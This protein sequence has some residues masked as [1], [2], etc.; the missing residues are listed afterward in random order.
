MCSFINH[1]SKSFMRFI[2]CFFDKIFLSMR[3]N[4]WYNYTDSLHPTNRF[5]LGA[6]MWSIGSLTFI[7]IAWTLTFAVVGEQYSKHLELLN[8]GPVACFIL[9][10]IGHYFIIRKNE[11]YLKAK[12]YLDK[13]PTKEHKQICI[14]H[15]LFYTAQIFGSMLIFIFVIANIN[16]FYPN[17]SK[18]EKQTVIVSEHQFPSRDSKPF[19]GKSDVEN[20]WNIY[21]KKSKDTK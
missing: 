5:H 16:N 14:K 1:R 17:N 8:I 7:C 11:Q 15:S 12:E 4:Y 3:V 10:V 20:S 6:S 18:L 9:G 21:E 13:F 2:S 19:K